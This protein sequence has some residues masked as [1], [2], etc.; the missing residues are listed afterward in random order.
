MILRNDQ[1]VYAQIDF[2]QL[3]CTR[4]NIYFFAEFNSMV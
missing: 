2:A 1:E 4:G 3:R